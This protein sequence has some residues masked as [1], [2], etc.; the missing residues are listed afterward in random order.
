MDYRNEKTSNGLN[1]WQEMTSQPYPE[2]CRNGM[3]MSPEKALSNPERHD[4]I[5][6]H[7]QWIR[8]CDEMP[9]GSVGARRDMR[10]E[11]ERIIH[12][13]VMEPAG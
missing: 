12:N 9:K 7:V 5:S 6:K 4:N 8:M 3:G 10:R 13:S 2:I 11:M 1:E